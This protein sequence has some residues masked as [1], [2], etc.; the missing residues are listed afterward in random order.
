VRVRYEPDSLSNP[1]VEELLCTFVVVPNHV[2]N[3]ST[4]IN[5]FCLQ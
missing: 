3:E 2:E 5:V 1:E 4:F